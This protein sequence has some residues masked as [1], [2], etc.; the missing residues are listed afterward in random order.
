M[1]RHRILGFLA[2]KGC[3]WWIREC[4]LDLASVYGTIALVPQILPMLD[5]R[6]GSVDRVRYEAAAALAGITGEDCRFA[7][8]GTALPITETRRC[9]FEAFAPR[10]PAPDAGEKGR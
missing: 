1:P 2:G 3:W 9:Y 10:R 5:Y 4:S 6:E 7:P 8:D